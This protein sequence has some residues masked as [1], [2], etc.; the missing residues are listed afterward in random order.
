M[1]KFQK[2]IKARQ[3]RRKGESVKEIAQKLKVA[4]GTASIWCRDIELTPRQIQ[5][6]HKRMV[7]GGYK[8]RLKGARLQKERKEQK[9]KYYLIEG[10]KDIGKLNKRVFIAGLSLYWGEGS[11]KGVGVRFYNSNPSIIRF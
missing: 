7:I 11:K 6:L 3:L 1:A 2:R 5:N 10:I 4:K 9:I 8:G